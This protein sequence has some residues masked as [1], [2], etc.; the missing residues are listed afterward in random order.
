MRKNRGLLLDRDGVINAEWGYVGS[1]ER[2]SFLPGLFPF[3]REARDAG[4]RLAIL[5]NQAGVAHGLYTE[6]DFSRLTAY[7]LEEMAREDIA[8]DLVLGCFF[9]AKGSVPAYT[10]PSFWRKPSPGMVLD[11]VQRLDLDPI[12]SAFVGDN[13]TDMQAARLGGIA[14]RILL[15]QKQGFDVPEEVR[16]ARTFEDVRA[17]LKA[18]FA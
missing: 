18:P 16:L 11:A 12:R 4:Y 5:T 15:T 1:R 10:R 17:A 3:L 2:F 13:L 6:E 9:S 8:V 14:R 7:M